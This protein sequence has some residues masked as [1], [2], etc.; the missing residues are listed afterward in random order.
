VDNSEVKEGRARLDQ[1][2]SK[3]SLNCLL[4][5]DMTSSYYNSSDR[6]K[7]MV[8]NHNLSEEPQCHRTLVIPESHTHSKWIKFILSDPL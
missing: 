1:V 5:A 8:F 6:T 7:E 2:R 4:N 3:E